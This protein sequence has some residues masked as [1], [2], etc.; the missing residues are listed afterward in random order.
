MGD[1]L[2]K[3]GEFKDKLGKWLNGEDVELGNIQDG[4]KKGTDF[5]HS[6][7][8]KHWTAIG[9]SFV[10]VIAL[11]VVLAFNT[12][13]E[14]APKNLDPNQTIF[15]SVKNGMSALSTI[16]RI[17]TQRKKIMPPDVMNLPNLCLI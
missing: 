13:D 16:L 7:T 14:A 6:L 15:L 11:A 9:V 1:L 17:M 12:A 8:W 10:V 4:M 2:S 5:F 3:I